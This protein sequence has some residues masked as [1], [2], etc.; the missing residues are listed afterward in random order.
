MQLLPADGYMNPSS[1]TIG[2]QRQWK[3][4]PLTLKG[5]LN[6]GD[7]RKGETTICKFLVLSRWHNEYGKA[8][9]AKQFTLNLSTTHGEDLCKYASYAAYQTGSN[10][11]FYL[12]EHF[13]SKVW[14]E[15]ER[16]GF[17]ADSTYQIPY[18]PPSQLRL[19]HLTR[20]V[21]VTETQYHRYQTH[22]DPS[23]HAEL[24]SDGEFQM[25]FSVTFLSKFCCVRWLSRNF[26]RPKSNFLSLAQRGAARKN[27]A[28][29]CDAHLEAVA[30]TARGPAEPPPPPVPCFD[31]ANHRRLHVGRPRQ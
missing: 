23:R 7:V 22:D 30:S 18:R 1:S 5:T 20:M 19:I 27:L 28:N 4:H 8:F 13:K 9:N 10:K 26:L 12:H 16:T 31:N 25:H 24:R 14:A 17:A 2:E 11:I 21:N 6:E 15:V 3:A 29:F